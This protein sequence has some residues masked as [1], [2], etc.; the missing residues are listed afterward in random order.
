MLVPMTLLNDETLHWL[1][2]FYVDF[3]N[4]EW[5]PEAN[6]AQIQ[7]QFLHL[8]FQAMESFLPLESATEDGSW[9]MEARYRETLTW[10]HCIESKTPPHGLPS[11]MI[12]PWKRPFYHSLVL[13]VSSISPLQPTSV[14]VDSDVAMLALISWING[15]F[16][17]TFDPG[18]IT[19]Y[20]FQFHIIYNCQFH[21]HL[22]NTSY[23]FPVVNSI[24]K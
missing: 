2:V 9:S 15:A 6:L 7:P 23:K 22:K 10:R 8:P 5:L 21:L 14:H 17:G 1:Q 19:L 4:A 24:L 13:L 11:V 12:T 16:L 18:S 20:Q 3:G